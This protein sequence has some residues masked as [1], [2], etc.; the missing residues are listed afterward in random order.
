[1]FQIFEESES[2]HHSQEKEEESD[3]EIT[4]GKK[5][6][7]PKILTD[8]YLE[9]FFDISD[10]Q[11]AKSKNNNLQI[12]DKGIYS[13]SKP[14]DAKWITHMIVQFLKKQFH[15]D[16]NLLYITDGTSGIGGNTIN[17][18]KYFYRVDSIEIN[19]VHFE[20][21][22]NNIETLELNNV[23]LI[24]DNFLNYVENT[25]KIS[26]IFFL[27]PPWGGKS[28]KNF[29]YFNL[30]LGKIPIYNIINVLFRKGYP[31]VVL[32]AP[33]NLNVSLVLAYCNYN[34]YFIYKKTHSNLLLIIFY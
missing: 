11:Y 10:I 3:C 19:N 17:F 20:V 26:D 21:L 8:V 15:Q 34:N 6:I 1:M 30:K 2:E 29:K 28:Y 23:K 32:K 5:Y 7:E 12:T 33:I 16:S 24:N 14:S 4:D 22:K 27:D 25:E 18:S 13:I 9:H 31:C